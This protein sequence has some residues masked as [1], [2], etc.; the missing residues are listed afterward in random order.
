MVCVKGQAGARPRSCS[1]GIE[2]DQGGTG[3]NGV[4]R[5]NGLKGIGNRGGLY[6]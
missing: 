1:V 2:V 5:I 6:I 4:M 3:E